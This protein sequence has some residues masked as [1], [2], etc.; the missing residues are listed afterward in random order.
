MTPPTSPST[1]GVGRFIDVLGEPVTVSSLYGMPLT[2][3]AYT[4][5]I[6]GTAQ[7][8]MLQ[9]GNSLIRIARADFVPSPPAT[10]PV[11]TS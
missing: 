1:V 4:E 5:L 9:L 8:G 3:G 7:T 6:A 10:P 2:L 11:T